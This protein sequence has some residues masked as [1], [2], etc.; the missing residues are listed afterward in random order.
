MGKMNKFL[1]M[2]LAL[3]MVLQMVPGF[4]GVSAADA[5]TSIA[6][7]PTEDAA[8][9]V[10]EYTAAFAG[11]G[12]NAPSG[13]ME[14][15]RDAAYLY[16]GVRYANANNLSLQIDGKAYT[17][18]LDTSASTAVV[19]VP[20]GDGGVTFPGYNGS[21]AI[22]ASLTGVYGTASLAGQLYF[23]PANSKVIA[24]VPAAHF[25]NV[26]G[27]TV[28]ARDDASAI[29]TLDTAAADSVYADTGWYTN[30][31]N[32][33]LAAKAQ[34]TQD[35]LFEQTVCIEK[36][37][38]SEAA[39]VSAYDNIQGLRIAVRDSGAAN[40]EL[41]LSIH[42]DESGKLSAVLA[43]SL[44]V[45]LGKRLGDT[46]KL[47]LQWNTDG[48][49][50]LYV[51][52][53]EIA[54]IEKAAPQASWAMTGD[55][56]TYGYANLVGEAKVTISG[57]VVKAPQAEVTM[58]SEINESV[59][60]AL[61]SSANPGLDKTAVKGNLQLPLGFT[62][63]Y[64]G[65][66]PL[67]WVSSQ[68]D[69]ISNTGIVKRPQADTAVEL[70]AYVGRTQ[71]AAITV[72][73]K[74]EE[75]EVELDPGPHIPAFKVSTIFLASFDYTANFIPA[76]NVSGSLGALW[77]SSTL[78]LSI[79]YQ[80]AT[81]AKI[82]IGDHV[83]TV[84]LSGSSGTKRV[85]LSFSKLGISVLYSNQ[86]VPVQV[87]LIG[88]AGTA[89][90]AEDTAK[91]YLTVKP[92]SRIIY[93]PNHVNKSFYNWATPSSGVYVL[94]TSSTIN[95]DNTD[96]YLASGSNSKID[97]TARNL[98]MQQTI[99]IERMPVET[100][101]YNATSS[102][103]LLMFMVDRQD[104][105][106]DGQLD[107]QFTYGI[108]GSIVNAGAKGLVLH[109]GPNAQFLL[110][111]KLGDTFKLGLQWN[112]DDT[113]DVYVD[114]VYIGSVEDA[115]LVLPWSGSDNIT[116][117]YRD[118]SD[119]VKVTLSG[120]TV[121]EGIPAANAGKLTQKGL[122]NLF[123]TSNPN[124]DLS[125][126]KA[127]LVL[128]ATYTG[129]GESQSI[130]WRSSNAAVVSET[131]KVTSQTVDYAV[132]LYAYVGEELVGKIALCVP[133]SNRLTGS[134]INAG[135]TADVTLD[136]TISEQNW[137]LNTA[138]MENG[139][140]AVRIGAQW[141][142]AILYLALQGSALDNAQL[143]LNGVNIDLSGSY[144][145]RSGDVCELAIPMD[146]LGITVRD[147]GLQIP[148]RLTVNGAAYDLTL[149]LCS[150]SWFATD[151]AAHKINSEILTSLDTAD[152]G[153]VNTPDG[154]YIYDHYNKS[155]VANS[156]SSV[157]YNFLKEDPTKPA[158]TPLWPVDQ[159]YYL[160]FDFL[161]T[162]MPVYDASIT[163]NSTR[164]S[165]CGVSW[166]VMGE[167]AKNTQD[168]MAD[169]TLFGM[170][171][172]GK[173]LVFVISGQDALVSFP[174]DK[175][176]GDHFRVAVAVNPDGDMQ[177]FIDGQLVRTV[178]NVEKKLSGMAPYKNKGTV[179]YRVVRSGD[180][181]QSGTD[182]FDVYMS[183]LAFG[184][185]YG[186]SVLDSLDF[187]DIKGR[188][189]DPMALTYALSLPA[190][191]TDSR[192]GT[193]VSLSWS[194]SDTAV[195]SN[196]GAVTRPAKSGQ[197]VVLTAT[198]PDGDSKDI[199]VYVKGKNAG[200]TVMTIV[201]DL[202]PE[203]SY[204]KV[205]D[206]YQFTL[207]TNNSSIIYNQGSAKPFNVVRLADADGVG[208]LHKDLLK[209]YVSDN[210]ATYTR[211]KDFKLLQV[212]RYWYLYG[213]E[214]NARYIKVHCTHFN[215]AEADFTG[216]L[217][218]MITVY[219][220]DQ[221][222]AADSFVNTASVQLT[223]ITATPK[224]DYPW[225][226]ESSALGGIFLAENYADAR[227]Y[228][229][230][231]LLSHYYENGCFF[232]RVPYVAAN[233]SVSLTVKAGKSDALDI[234]N[235]EAVYE[236]VYGAREVTSIYKFTGNRV[237]RTLTMSDGRMI[238]M[239]VD[240]SGYGVAAQYST[241]GGYSWTSPV[242]IPISV[243]LFNGVSGF[244]Y[245][246]KLDRIIIAGYVFA[247]DETRTNFIYSD[248]CG[249][250][251][252]YLGGTTFNGS[253]YVDGISLASNDGEGGN[254]DYVI[255]LGGPLIDDQGATLGLQAFS[256]YSADGGKTW[257]RSEALSVQASI[258]TEAGI[259]ENTVYE[260]ADG[261]LVM[262]ARWQ[263]AGI[264]HFAVYYSAD[265]GKSWTD[266]PAMSQV[267][268][269]NTNPV[270]LDD[271]GT[272]VLMW[273]GNTALGGNSYLRMPLSIAVSDDQQQLMRFENI[274]DLYV[275]YSLQSLDTATQNQATN[276]H[277]RI[278]GDKLIAV[279]MNNF[280]G[281]VQLHLDDYRDFIYKTKGAYDSFEGRTVE[282]EGWASVYG[283][284]IR[285][286]D[287]AY[288]GSYSMLLEGGSAVA[289][290]VP[291]VTAGQLSMQVYVPGK[292]DFT[293]ELQTAF[294][295]TSQASPIRLVT[296]NGALGGVKLANGW[297][298]LVFDLALEEGKASLLING[299]PA[300]VT[301]DTQ[302]G[303]YICYVYL[304]TGS[305]LYVDEFTLLD[306]DEQIADVAQVNGQNYK[307]LESALEAAEGATVKLLGGVEE[308]QLTIP[309]GV[310]LDLNGFVLK[311]DALVSY[312]QILDSTDGV[313]AVQCGRL[314]LAQDNG[315][316]PLYD[317]QKGGYRF[318]S[319]RLQN[320]GTK[321]KADQVIF[322]FR[323]AFDNADAYGLLSGGNTGASVGVQL[324]GTGIDARNYAFE[325]GLLQ[326]YAQLVMEYP[327][328][329]AC[330]MLRVSGTDSLAA[331]ESLAVTP[332][333]VTQIGVQG[334]GSAIS[335][336]A[337]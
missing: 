330:L 258:G 152:H 154:C 322:G 77:T 146:E 173:N 292:A 178:K 67:S 318:F 39:T 138:V 128:P 145:V 278:H 255:G 306:E 105:D 191:F 75:P 328:A 208:R 31:Y 162:A 264:H 113:A 303:D 148:A 130:L 228:L 200:N 218:E 161:A 301:V 181:A 83:E 19:Q 96:A 15:Y 312:G 153:V 64:M 78:Y 245:D 314:Q 40:Q 42:A 93:F 108:L 98:M 265:H 22:S 110:N 20:L 305:D 13:A 56:L 261:T 240:V 127:D 335:Y 285:S 43:N 329:G 157:Y 295:N 211:I 253:C 238:G 44:V 76:G 166:V 248:D 84:S 23:C 219:H 94:D 304:K 8:S 262:Y 36:L 174:L 103:G 333:V 135:F 119:D 235:K 7:L 188:N 194:S 337:K 189:T 52:Q 270:L 126:V 263:D 141:N 197:Q 268:T 288:A 229:D 16:V 207:D 33:A 144:A 187:E 5:G 74:A 155:S 293:L 41:W 112:M 117:D 14:V 183:N 57:A 290:S 71:V 205:A 66:V 70:T 151:N 223:N 269:V 259:S 3:V 4:G 47:G 242:K 125:A 311:A 274:Q 150:V 237:A 149:E 48:T 212:G 58:D 254:V 136:G 97:H 283:N 104:V 302:I 190:T 61:L 24:T 30:V 79:K 25:K 69:V 327:G 29:V 114:Y 101:S 307:S 236:V 310:K 168:S 116:Y 273:S 137:I 160:Q 294:S 319:Y 143:Q 225:A 313:G 68:P 296:E 289:R 321:Q 21:V 90:L 193:T 221:F 309:A 201:N 276:P 129:N 272:A 177:V 2:L 216:V 324:S 118:L 49:T 133:G 38:V 234:S 226:V 9:I 297:N 6:A 139:A 239:D 62:S 247:G 170:Y 115:T 91:I 122:E 18:A 308:S 257:Q 72:T 172:N 275:K 37:P 230:G 185:Y 186:E 140:A 46:F 325:A 267:Y 250:N 132:A 111:R 86:V 227:F 217:S 53:F 27:M 102:N 260:M 231:Q 300:E 60:L 85:D 332:A 252:N 65:G 206:L 249:A 243:E 244:I 256:A 50:V 179:V 1:A 95:T 63:S 233:G 204:G 222:G 120:V 107:G 246:E 213:F 180:P 317:A 214:A 99:C 195:V 147:Y 184:L 34:R 12:G 286:G 334:N 121:Y 316:L 326:A 142:T 175:Q 131:G 156:S 336:T 124:V 266:T 251:W 11:Q 298:E 220:D 171:N 279:W 323:L 28:A 291:S 89:Y 109:L 202:A 55:A 35:L 163:G 92:S 59:V 209:L 224:T 165:N 10:W 26:V 123:A 277:F 320:Y 51:D 196:S 134:K 167:R 73:V 100:F 169:C 81:Q 182:N 106:G 331:G 159:T 164:S 199:V 232:V 88:S 32:N 271:N 210:N 54:A 299:Q 241:D 158:A 203:S 215:G 45:D 287:Q 82:T 192:L 80:N 176:V 198:T 87:E 281:V 315:Q 17:Y 280:T 282:Y 284:A